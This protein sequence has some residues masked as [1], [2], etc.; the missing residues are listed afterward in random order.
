M[1]QHGRETIYSPETY[2]DENNLLSVLTDALNVHLRN[3]GR[4]SAL[5]D[6]YKGKQLIYERKKKHRPDINHQIVENHALEIVD[7][8]VGY[9]FGEP[10]QYVSR[11]DREDTAD[12]INT[13]NEYMDFEDKFT[14]DIEMAEW[15]A[16]SGTSYRMVLPDEMAGKI[17][18]HSPFEIDILDPR[19][20]FIV[21]NNGFGKKPLM[22][23]MSYINKKNKQGYAVYTSS[24]R[25]D[26]EDGV[27]IKS[28]PHPINDIP[29][30]EYP[31]NNSKLGSFEVVEDLLHAMNLLA[32]DRMN[33]L[34]QFV[35]SFIAFINCD[36]DS[37]KFEALKEAGAIAVKGTQGLPASVNILAE[38]LDQSGTQISKEDM[39][40]MMLIICGMPDRNSSKT[41]GGDTGKAVELRDGWSAAEVR[42]KETEAMFKRSERR[43]LKIVLRI[44]RGTVGTN[45]QL[46]DIDIKFT[47]NK[48][49]NI[50]VK[51]QA[52]T[53][54]IEAGIHP[55]IAIETCGIFS[56]ANQVYLD[57]KEILERKATRKHAGY[58]RC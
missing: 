5:Y 11:G 14:K 8:K 32:S 46:Q 17:P 28:E 1:R 50:L 35:Q 10:I 45:L 20:T 33:A 37:D 44:M 56:D 19:H 42:A 49:D 13:L 54:M 6:I 52:L 48:T 30:I 58:L 22:G 26:V 38:Q 2:I 4:T 39:Y 31:A 16:V 7:F 3:Q 43:F 9:V 34:D 29:I 51:T 18:D 41:T 53:N 24:H 12:E 25:Y 55:A 23:V 57:S 15:S 36:L 47:R 21:Y 40:K 27:I